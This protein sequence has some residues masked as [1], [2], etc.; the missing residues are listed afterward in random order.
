MQRLEVSSVVRLI[1]KS[2]GVKGLNAELNPICHLLAF[3]GAHHILHISRVR[4]N[5]LHKVQNNE[6]MNTYIKLLMYH[7]ML[8]RR[9]YTDLSETLPWR[10]GFDYRPV[11]F[12]FV[13]SKVALEQISLRVLRLPLS[14]S[15]DQRPIFVVYLTRLTSTAD[16]IIQLNISGLFLR[17]WRHWNMQLTDRLIWRSPQDGANLIS[18]LQTAVACTGTNTALSNA[19][20]VYWSNTTTVFFDRQRARYLYKKGL[21]S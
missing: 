4:V 17:P 7:H 1:Y 16:T 11:P 8:Y 2:L 12:G 18:V 9:S 6:W 21:N 3:I 10:I 19:K 13:V 20:C 15:S 5:L 14:V